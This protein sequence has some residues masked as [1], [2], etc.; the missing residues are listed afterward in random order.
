[1]VARTWQRNPCW[2]FERR[3][4]QAKNGAIIAW[5]HRSRMSIATGQTPFDKANL[6][7]RRQIAFKNWDAVVR[8]FTINITETSL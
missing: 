3:R 6:D 4:G 8:L 7:G 2:T 5:K 1:M